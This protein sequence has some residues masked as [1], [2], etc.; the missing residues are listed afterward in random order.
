MLRF[1]DWKMETMLAT[2][3]HRRNSLCQLTVYG[4][5]SM[6]AEGCPEIGIFPARRLVGIIVMRCRCKGMD[7]IAHHEREDAEV[8]EEGEQEHTH[9]ANNM[10]QKRYL[11]PRGEEH[12]VEASKVHC[13]GKEP[14]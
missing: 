8:D 13:T 3:R 6:P 11:L 12:L 2:C 9:G 14:V 1:W 7:K 5:F 4:S 10:V